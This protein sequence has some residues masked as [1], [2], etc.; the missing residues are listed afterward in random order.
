MAVT[1]LVMKKF[2]TSVL[3]N[4]EVCRVYASPK[5][6]EEYRRYH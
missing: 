4:I 2:I 5:S 6:S 1:Q 3:H